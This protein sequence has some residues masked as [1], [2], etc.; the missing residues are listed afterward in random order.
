VDINADG[1]IDILTGCYSHDEMSSEMGGLFQVLW[2]TERGFKSPEI[3]EG[4]DGRRLLV[5]I[6]SAQP[7]SAPATPA[8]EAD[9][10]SDE[11]EVV[12]M[13][14]EVD[15]ML[16]RICTRPTAVDFDNDGD[17]DIVTG[18]FGGTFVHFAGAGAGVFAPQ[19]TLLNDV[20][21]QPLRVEMHSD[22]VFADWDDDGDLDLLSGAVM[23][24]VYIAV[25]QGSRAEPKYAPFETLI[26]S[27]G[28]MAQLASR[29]TPD[30]SHLTM[31]Q[32]DTRI[33]VDDVN[34]DGKLDVLVGDTTQLILPA[35]GL[36]VATA[37]AKYDEL[38]KRQSEIWQN[39]EYGSEGPTQEQMDD[40]MKRYQ[41]LEKEFEKVVKRDST[42]FVWVYH[43]R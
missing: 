14:M 27:A 37:Q 19:G 36:D 12:I 42:G 34:G 30:D 16:D 7:A 28:E 3:L 32:N 35:D 26:R 10:T 13:G 9:E 39:V 43:R 4:S 20:N 18:N 8:E 5:S 11:G 17:L 24:G 22:P 31:P 41:E 23:G 2:G 25:N 38:M 21:G 15:P 33:W 40:Q 6:V 1:R 29:V